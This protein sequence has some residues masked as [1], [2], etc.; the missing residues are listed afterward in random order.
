MGYSKEIIDTAVRIM[1]QRR[2]QSAAEAEQRRGDYFARYPRALEI[3]RELARNGARAAKAVVMGGDVRSH[4][5]RLKQDSLAL[6]AELAAV[7][8]DSGVPEDYLEIRYACPLCQDMGYIDGRICSCMRQLL[9]QV[10]YDRLNALFPLSLSSFNTFSLDLYED[11]PQREG[12]VSPRKRMEDIFRYCKNYALR[13]DPRLSPSLLMQGA[14]GLGKTHLSLAIAKTAIDMGF[15][16][17]YGSA[18]SLMGKLEKE[19]FHRDWEDAE[20]V[21]NHLLECDLLILDDLG[22]EFSTSFS[23][24]AIY[25][26]LNSRLMASK[27]T[28]I[29]TNLTMRELEKQYSQRLVSRIMGNH[30]R[31]EFLGSDIRQKK[32]VIG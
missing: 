23:C 21:E 25:N 22:T 28:V 5:E 18:P 13:F 1:E 27:P 19:K 9:R 30:V 16:V 31:L 12:G 20:T 2:S 14:T 17:I 3:E 7:L 15:G 24:S 32:R 4:L 10:A 26:I 8:Q 29:S 6:Q 11:E